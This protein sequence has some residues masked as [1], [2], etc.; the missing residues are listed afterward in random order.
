MNLKTVRKV[1]MV[2]WC[3]VILLFIL[4]V[5]AE[6]TMFRVA[7]YLLLADIAAIAA[8]ALLYQR[9]PH[10]KKFLRTYGTFCPHCGEELD[11]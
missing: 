6:G 7:F 5:L 3:A 1:Q 10:C 8:V 2:L 11:R 9:C 4:G